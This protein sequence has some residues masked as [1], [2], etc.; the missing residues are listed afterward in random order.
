MRGSRRPVQGK[1]DYAIT[2]SYG[3]GRDEDQ[4]ATGRHAR[5]P[6]LA[7]RDDQAPWSKRCLNWEMENEQE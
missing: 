7:Q 3:E 1:A 6:H 2:Q 4:G 5:R